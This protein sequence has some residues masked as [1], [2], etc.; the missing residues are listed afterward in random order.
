MNHLEKEAQEHVTRKRQAFVRT[1][2]GKINEVESLIRSNVW[3]CREVELARDHLTSSFLWVREA[4][5]KY[6]VK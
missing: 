6:G 3:D 1:L 4:V 5:E 2:G